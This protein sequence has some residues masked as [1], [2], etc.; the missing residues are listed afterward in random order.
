MRN[1]KIVADSSANVLKLQNMSFAA[2]PMKVITNEREF[3][4]VLIQR[5]RGLCSYYA[6]KG[7]MLV[8]FEKL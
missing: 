7:G 5:C 3:V 8:G 2:A 4:D 6:E 1:V